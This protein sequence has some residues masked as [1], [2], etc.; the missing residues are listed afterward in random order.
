M[1]LLA[2]AF[3]L[4]AISSVPVPPSKDTYQYYFLAAGA[5]AG[6]LCTT[7][8]GWDDDYF[9][10]LKSFLPLSVTMAAVLSLFFHT[11]LRFVERNSVYVSIPEKQE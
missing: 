6:H 11:A 1:F 10:V 2:I 3:Y 7:K 5:L 8:W 9:M 4:S